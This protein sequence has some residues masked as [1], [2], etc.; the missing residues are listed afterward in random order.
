MAELPKIA[1]ARLRAKQ[2]EPTASGATGAPAALEHPDAN[3]LA[4]FAERT[5]TERERTEILHHLSEC[6]D[7]REVVSLIVPPLETV[8]PARV[9]AGRGLSPFRLFRWG[10]LAAALGVVTIVVVS[11]PNFWRRNSAPSSSQPPVLS[12]ADSVRPA[13]PASPYS[14]NAVTAPSQAKTEA[15]EKMEAGE[16]G[17][18]AYDQLKKSAGMV[19]DKELDKSVAQLQARQQATVMSSSQPQRVLRTMNAP[20]L[21]RT[22]EEGTTAG[23]GSARVRAAPAPAPPPAAAG[24]PSAGLGAAG[25]STTQTVVIRPGNTTESVAVTADA[26]QLQVESRSGLGGFG[27]NLKAKD[28]RTTAVWSLSS[29]GQVQRSSGRG[30]LSRFVDVAPGVKFRAIAAM[31]DEVWAGGED[32]V[33]YHSIDAG[34]NW[35][36]VAISIKKDVMTETIVGIAVHDPK[37][38]SIVT[39]SGTGFTSKDGGKHWH[40]QP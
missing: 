29:E 8:E 28:E 33:L 19:R 12:A 3:L 35:V 26:P 20:V 2:A 23:A 11:H 22:E 25:K 40:R 1:R 30:T 24:E 37:H 39:T 36:Q 9:A 10:T 14:T 32:G 34:T 27:G 4:A 5:L 13:P 38:L 18:E 17:P 16:T 31:G 15:K 7:C 21:G 6:R